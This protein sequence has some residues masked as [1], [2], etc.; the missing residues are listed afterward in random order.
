[1]LYHKPLWIDEKGQVTGT[2][3]AGFKLKALWPLYKGQK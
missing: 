2:K 1:M 3:S